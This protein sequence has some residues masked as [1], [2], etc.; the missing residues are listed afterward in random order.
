MS[1][2]QLIHC[3]RCGRE[4]GE[5]GARARSVLVVEGVE[6][7]V[8]SVIEAREIGVLDLCEPCMA[9]VLVQWARLIAQE[10]LG[11]AAGALP[12]AA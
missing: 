9:V 1:C 2:T 4:L 3:D 10:L 8:K 6:Y 11:V 5:R 7:A 12:K